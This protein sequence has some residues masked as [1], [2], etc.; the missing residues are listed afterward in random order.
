MVS[1]KYVELLRKH[2][3]AYEI[4]VRL[5]PKG[6]LPI[7]CIRCERKAMYNEHLDKLAAATRGEI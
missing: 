3:N 2:G 5:A 4:F 1:K 6:Y 7:H